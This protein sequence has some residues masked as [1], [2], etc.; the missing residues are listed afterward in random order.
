MGE[1]DLEWPAVEYPLLCVLGVFG[2]DGNTAGGQFG[3]NG[4]GI[5][6][7]GSGGAPNAD[8]RGM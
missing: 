7:G 6:A 5:N 3:S 2:Y 8:G 4:S 1:E